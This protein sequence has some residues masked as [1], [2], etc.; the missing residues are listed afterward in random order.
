MVDFLRDGGDGTTEGSHNIF[1]GLNFIGHLLPAIP[2]WLMGC[3]AIM[4]GMHIFPRIPLLE[5]LAGSS[6]SGG[7]TQRSD[8]IIFCVAFFTGLVYAGIHSTLVVSGIMTD[9][10][11]LV[12][13]NLVHTNIGVALMFG[14]SMHWIFSRPHMPRLT[15]NFAMPLVFFT[16]GAGIGFHQD[17]T[18]APD[19]NFPTVRIED[20][21]SNWIH[22]SFGVSMIFSGALAGVAYKWR[23]WQVVEGTIHILSA[24]LLTV[25]TDFF[26]DWVRRDHIGVGNLIT[27]SVWF[28]VLHTIGF[29]LYTHFAGRAEDSA[30]WLEA[31]ERGE[32]THY[33]TVDGVRDNLDNQEEDNLTW[34]PEDAE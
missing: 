18:Y 30:N 13:D 15:I 1:L 7:T 3:V 16:I 11:R 8:L 20:P 12:M 10:S 34:K 23:R 4:W 2:L 6:S 29:G 27:F 24:T 28:A 32:I 33:T 21:I 9:N 26:V 22:T 19:P 14:A 17:H 5:R 31:N 25:S